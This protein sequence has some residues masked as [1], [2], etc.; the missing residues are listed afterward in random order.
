MIDETNNVKDVDMSS[1][2]NIQHLAAMVRAKRGDKGLRAVAQEIG[3]ISASTLSRI[4]Q[5][6]VPDLD[7][8]IRICRWLQ[9]EPQYFY[10]M[11]DDTQEEAKQT[12]PEIIAAHLRADRTLDPET[13][14]TLAKM[15]QLIYDAAKRGD[16]NKPS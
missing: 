16:L 11:E 1:A 4:E 2:V 10:R 9:V 6:N 3:N 7:T 8:F 13:A 15:I 5:G 14:A 12:T